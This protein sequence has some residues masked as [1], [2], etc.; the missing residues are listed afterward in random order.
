MEE[1]LMDS[2]KARET[3]QQDERARRPYE[4]PSI[5]WEED[6]LPYVY[7][8]CGKMSGAACAAGMLSS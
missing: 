1:P 5:H 7:S 3:E 2:E 6:F 4:R 8:T